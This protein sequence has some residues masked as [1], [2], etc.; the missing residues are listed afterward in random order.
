MPLNLTRSSKRRTV[1]R[2]AIL[3][4]VTACAAGS[5]A[6]LAGAFTVRGQVSVY[7]IAGTR[8][9]PPGAQLAFRGVSTRDL[10]RL[11][12]SGSSTGPH[13]GQVRADSGG[14]GASFLP[15]K[16][17]KPGETVTVQ[18]SLN[19]RG[20]DR[21]TYRFQVAE[22]AGPIP[23]APLPPAARSDGDV[24]R[25]H[26]EP[27]LTPAAVTVTR[28]GGASAAGEIFL[29][30]QQGPLQSGPMIVDQNGQLVWFKPLPAK[31]MA[32]DFRVQRYDGKPV[33]T[34][35]QGYL[36]AGAGVGEGV[37]LD[38]SYRQ[39]ATV[40]AAGGQSADL[41]EFML[42]PRGTALI[43]A[44][45]PVW[46]DGSA[47]H[48]AKRQV[49]IDSVVQEIDV[50]TGLLLFQWDSL[51][52]VPLTD[53][54]TEPPKQADAPLDHFH[55]NSVEEGRDRN[56]LISARNTSAAYKVDRQTGKIVWTLGGKHSSF[57]MR[58]GATFSFQHDVRMRSG[59]DRLVTLFDNGGG[60]PRL[61][62]ESRG[63]TLKLDL[64]HMT[65]TRLAE[66]RQPSPAPADY[67]GNHQQLANGGAFLGWGQ[68]P[69]FTEL[70]SRGQLVLQGRFV[71][72]TAHYRAYLLPW[73]AKPA[74]RPALSIAAT[75]GQTI[76][77]ASWN[78]AN[79]VSSWRVLSG[80]RAD[81]LS[82]VA[83]SSNHGFETAIKTAAQGYLAVQALDAA[84]HVLSTSTVVERHG[85]SGS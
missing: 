30:P 64:T 36:G 45:Y 6:A 57:K 65:A 11:V 1:R 82:P 23:Y 7:P 85:A 17:F 80:D 42:T 74:T 4:T 66:Q 62:P 84:G 26:S 68:Q 32:A 49:V 71:P 63:L 13:H 28:Q 77:Y 34:W 43:T 54:Y 50:K 46:S 44:Y 39:I 35:W 2:V 59:S 83:S 79:Q 22:P 73:N 67:E 24:L 38:S 56:L 47:V 81:R 75:G 8:V 12:V 51:D 52:H 16:P 37:I 9:A 21:G 53:S 18:T 27:G 48:A 15:D 78:G 33:L 19:V 41:H 70:D 60:P 61:S 5:A 14:R 20:A 76:V 3:L 58:S 25:F 40:R 55:V 69:Y 72:A 29:A 31:T 10:E